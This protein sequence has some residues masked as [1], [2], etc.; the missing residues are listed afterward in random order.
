LTVTEIDGWRTRS[1][2]GQH[3]CFTPIGVMMHHTVGLGAGTLADIVAKVKANFFVD[4]NGVI[5]LV[6]GARANHAGTGAQQVLDEVSR[7]VAPSGTAAVRGLRDG[8]FGN[9]Y[10]YGFEN[11]NK[12]DG[13]DPWPAA[14]LD[15]MVKGAAA[16]CQRHGWSASRV[17]S[18]AEWTSNKID[19]KGIDMNAFRARVASLF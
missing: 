8:P 15:S 13:V 2:Q 7:G 14:Q 16:L 10:F 3:R 18:H 5:S 12:G 11:E 1:S 4:K 9:G 6:A 17:I 19:P